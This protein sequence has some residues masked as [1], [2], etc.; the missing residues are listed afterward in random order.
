M[1]EKT[2]KCPFCGEEIL[3]VAIKCKYCQSMLTDS[4]APPVAMPVEQAP[5]PQSA[6]AVSKEAALVWLK[7]VGIFVL[8]IVA[9]FFAGW[10][11]NW[12]C[13]I[14]LI[15]WLMPLFYGAI[16]GSII[17]YAIKTFC[18]EDLA[19][20][21]FMG[22][23]AVIV[24]YY[25]AWV[26]FVNGECGIFTLNPG[27]LWDMAG[28]IH[29]FRV[30][31]SVRDGWLTLAWMGEFM[32]VF[33]GVALGIIFSYSEEFLCPVCKRWSKEMTNP[34]RLV[35]D[36]AEY[37]LISPDAIMNMMTTPKDIHVDH[38]TV[39]VFECPYCKNGAFT[40]K[41]QKVIILNGHY[42]I[43]GKTLLR[44]MFCPAE[45]IKVLRVFIEAKGIPCKE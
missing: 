27:K 19:V 13:S 18:T 15:F 39:K 7:R 43:R 14:P 3:A 29:P 11:Y 25:S 6:H 17:F 8:S 31:H 45:K 28:M 22:L 40:L 44:R 30:R 10:L 24:A 37:E 35:S 2:K 34:Y 33:G 36:K 41:K 26:W 42:E 38:Y 32:S 12:S 5:F 1:S 4:A 20:F 23:I 16:A 9:I 21:I